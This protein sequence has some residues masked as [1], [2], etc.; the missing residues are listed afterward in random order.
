MFSCYSDS[1]ADEAE[2]DFLYPVL[3][4]RRYGTQ[5]RWQLA[6]VFSLFGGESPP[7]LQGNRQFTLFPIYFQQRSPNPAD[8]YTALMPFYGH[9]KNR[10]FRDE[11][12]V[13][14]FPI[15]SQTH[16]RDMVTDNYL[17]PIF[18]VHRGDG[19]RG[20][21][22]WPLVG[23]EHKDVTMRTNGFGEIEII[24]GHDNFFA[25]WPIHFSQNTGIGSENPSRYRADLPFYS[26][27]RSPQRD[28]TS[29]LWPFFTWVDDRG[30]KYRE[31]QMPYPVVV[32]SRGPGKTTTRFWPLFSR[33]H[34]ES[35]ETDYYL[36]PLY[37]YDGI[38]ADPL[39][40]GRTRI[41]L[42]CFVNKKEKNLETGALLHRVDLWPLFTY[43]QDFNGDQRLQILAPIEPWLPGN[44]G[45]ER[46]WSP[47]WSVWRAET[48]PK[49]GTTSRSLLWNLYRYDKAPASRRY[50]FMF[51]LFQY[52][53]NPEGEAVRLFYIPIVK[54]KP[55]NHP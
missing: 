7:D 18:D 39:D 17:Y 50:S 55:A 31:W 24:P 20:W 27:L 10:L 44:V 21:E 41:L 16:R 15:Y 43:Q 51:G 32:I 4:Y 8:N 36:W 49:R 22:V 12:F 35:L 40:Y 5:Y 11:I 37:R 46:S 48:S 14:M 1:T 45:V 13:V 29:V 9:I 38:H 34:N 28:S 33:S 26:L 2:D 53:S 19:L 47:L 25:L 6:Q 23:N 42:Y 54:T 30:Q 3:T 52:Q